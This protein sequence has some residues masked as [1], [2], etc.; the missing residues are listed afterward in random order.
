[1]KNKKEHINVQVVYAKKNTQRI[2]EMHVS[3]TTKVSEVISL[4]GIEKYLPANL[5]DNCAIA[6]WGEIVS[7][8]R[9]LEEGDRVE[10]CPPL[11]VDPKE[12]RRIRAKGRKKMN[13][14]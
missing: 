13:S 8:D 6:V 9:I 4:S 5:I 2:I 3:P 7:L 14:Y 1:M 12:L 11:G 10:V